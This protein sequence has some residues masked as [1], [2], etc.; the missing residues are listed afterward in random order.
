M[1]ASLLRWAL[2]GALA[3]LLFPADTR[4]Q[5]GQTGDFYTPSLA[6]LIRFEVDGHSAF[7]LSPK[8]TH[9]STNPWV[10]YSPTLFQKDTPSKFNRYIFDELLQRGIQIA[11][12]DAGDS[13]GSPAGTKIYATFYSAATEKYHLSTRPCLLAQSR[14]GLML[15]NWA[16]E[17]PTSVLCIA[18]VYPVTDLTNWPRERDSPGPFKDAKSAYGFTNDEEFKKHLAEFSPVNHLEPLAKAKVPILHLHGDSDPWVS[19]IANSCAL[20]KRY[21]ML[22]GDATI[23]VIRH[24][25]HDTSDDFFRSCDLLTFLLYHSTTLALPPTMPCKDSESGNCPN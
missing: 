1:H 12:V 14:G 24:R 15:Y 21:R 5:Q 8:A 13:Y 3:F 11:G 18:G 7:L 6:S 9:G 17:H 16:E 4:E 19:Y 20:A 2:I 25:E 22:G 23:K 10:W